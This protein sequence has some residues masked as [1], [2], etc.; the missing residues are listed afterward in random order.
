MELK[1]TW[2]VMVKDRQRLLIEPY[3]IEIKQTDTGIQNQRAFNGIE[4]KQTDTGIQNQRA[5]NRTI[6]N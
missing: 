4:I 3:G 2:R 1:F 6:W 5:F